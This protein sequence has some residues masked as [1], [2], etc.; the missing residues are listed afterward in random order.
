MDNVVQRLDPLKELVCVVMEDLRDVKA[1]Q[2][3]LQV[4]LIRLE[5]QVPGPSVDVACGQYT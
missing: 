3:M 2:T 5:Q 1:Q 4:S